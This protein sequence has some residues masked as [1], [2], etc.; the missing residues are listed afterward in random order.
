MKCE[1]LLSK[2]KQLNKVQSCKIDQKHLIRFGGTLP[3]LLRKNNLKT[4]IFKVFLS[5]T[6]LLVATFSETREPTFR[7]YEAEQGIAML[8]ASKKFSTFSS[9]SSVFDI[10]KQPTSLNFQG[11]FTSNRTFFAD[12]QRNACIHFQ[13]ICCSTRYS[14][15][16]LDQKHFKLFHC[17]PPFLLQINNLKV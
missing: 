1:Q 5:L 15:A 2:N 14:D 8:N 12:F 11:V 3:F 7:K 13:K 4:E 6:D 9:H 17:T 16:K 10:D